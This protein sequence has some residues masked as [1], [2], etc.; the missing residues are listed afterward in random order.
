VKFRFYPTLFILV[1]HLFSSAGCMKLYEW[2]EEHISLFL[3][4]FQNSKKE[5]ENSGTKVQET[6][7]FVTKEEF[8]KLKRDMLMM[9]GEFDI[10]ENQRTEAVI[11]QWQLNEWRIYGNLQQREM[12]KR[13]RYK[14]TFLMQRSARRRLYD[15]NIIL[16]GIFDDRIKH[17]KLGAIS[18][19]FEGS[20][21]I[22]LG[23]A[24]LYEEGAPTVRDIFEDKKVSPHLSNIVATDINEEGARYIDIYNEKKQNLPF[25][26]REIN[27]R[28]VNPGQFL[29]LA[30]EFMNETTPVILRSCNSGPDLYYKPEDVKEHLRSAVRAFY[31]RN[32]LYFFAKFV[33]FKPA[34]SIHFEH[35]GRDSGIG[36][37][38]NS[39]AWQY[40]DWEKRELN[41][42]FIPEK[43]KVD[44]VF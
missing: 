8:R 30:E 7:K 28:L 29:S 41:K 1:F 15:H 40:V 5:P 43:L 42:S 9:M 17:K 12:H 27:P 11:L 21:F 4:K 19:L 34:G 20:V 13:S 35:L 26:V 23:S 38:H 18:S 39:H 14:N 16:S 3:G 37:A 10:F 22:D 24:I 32:V 31:D 33:L 36:N 25:P 44:L 6:N 2:N